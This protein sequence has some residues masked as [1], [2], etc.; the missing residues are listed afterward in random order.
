MSIHKESIFKSTGE[1]QRIVKT[2]AQTTTTTT[3]RTARREHWELSKPWE[4]PPRKLKSGF[5]TIF[6]LI[7]IITLAK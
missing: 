1:K 3:D 2:V 4:H 6:G 7:S 5:W